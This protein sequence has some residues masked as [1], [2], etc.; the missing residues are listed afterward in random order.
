MGAVFG[1]SA[2]KSEV[3]TRFR[4]PAKIKKKKTPR[5]KCKNFLQRDDRETP[6]FLQQR[7]DFIGL[8]S[9]LCQ[10]HGKVKHLE[11]FATQRSAAR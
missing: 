2:A 8:P 10:N 4:L 5:Q 3:S 7:C 9:I 11:S 1:K 6:N